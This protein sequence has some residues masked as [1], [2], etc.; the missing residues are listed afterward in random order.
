MPPVGDVEVARAA[1][2]FAAATAIGSFFVLTRLYPGDFAARARPPWPASDARIERPAGQAVWTER[3][4]FVGK[5]SNGQTI[6]AQMTGEATDYDPRAGSAATVSRP[7]DP[8]VEGPG[9]YF[10]GA[11]DAPGVLTFV[12]P[13]TGSYRFSFSPCAMWGA[14]G[15]SRYARTN[16]TGSRMRQVR[17]PPCRVWLLAVARS[18]T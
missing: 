6:S 5:F 4:L 15:A 16:R 9:G 7:R 11:P 3:A 17:T 8:N 10:F 12:A 14:P 2:G 13:A 1:P 18:V